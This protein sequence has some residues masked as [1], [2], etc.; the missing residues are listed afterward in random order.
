VGI[1]HR[2]LILECVAPNYRAGRADGQMRC[3]P[4][5]AESVAGRHGEMAV[6]N[7]VFVGC[8]THFTDV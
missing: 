8:S 4:A 6:F 2:D 5:D 1:E 3:R 7:S